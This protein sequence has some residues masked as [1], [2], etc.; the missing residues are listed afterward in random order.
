MY[1][2]KGR[3]RELALRF[4]KIDDRLVAG[5]SIVVGRVKGE[6]ESIRR[7]VGQEPLRC[8]LR[9]IGCSVS[10]NWL[11]PPRCLVA[12]GGWW[13]VRYVVVRCWLALRRRRKDAVDALFTKWRSSTA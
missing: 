4:L 7:G 2:G 12:V 6:G 9:W 11:R 13:L 8:S 3:E 10:E 5:G 1:R